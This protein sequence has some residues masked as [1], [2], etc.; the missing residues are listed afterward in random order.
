VNVRARTAAFFSRSAI[1]A[2]AAPALTPCAASNA[3]GSGASTSRQVASV[4][5]RVLVL[6][7]LALFTS[8][9]LASPASALQTHNQGPQVS[10]AATPNQAANGGGFGELGGLA[11]GGG[12]DLYVIDTT[13]S[14]SAGIENS[15]AVH[16]F[17]N[18]GAYQST[19]D[20]T[21]VV[22]GPG[23]LA[24]NGDSHLTVEPSGTLYLTDTGN[25]RVL[26]F[27]SAGEALKSFGTEGQL[28]GA[29]TPSGSFSYACGVAVDPI[30]GDV[31]LAD[32]FNHR[33]WIFDSSGTYQ[34]RIA[35][36][37]IS[38]PCGL[39]FDSTG[40]LYVR[41]WFAGNVV[42]FHRAGARD[43]GFER[44]A[45]QENNFTPADPTDDLPGPSDI[46]VDLVNNDLYVDAGSQVSHFDQ[47]GTLLS[48]FAKDTFQSGFSR[49]IAVDGMAGKVYA[50]DGN[51][52]LSFGPLVTL[53]EASTGGVT[54]ISGSEATVHG[55]V[56]PA[57]LDAECEFEYGTDTTYGSTAPC[58]PAGPYTSPTNVSAE[59]T[60]LLEGTV[61]HYRLRA[62]NVN[63][64][65]R[66]Q[67]AKFATDGAPIVSFGAAGVETTSA[68]LRASI[69]P[70]GSPA[71]YRFEYVEESQFQATGFG[72]AIK[73]PT[74]DVALGS[75]SSAK[76]VSRFVS[77]LSP[78]TK[79][80]FRVIAANAVGITET[81]PKSFKTYPVPAPAEA[82][83]F[84]GE[85]FLP[86]DRAWELVTPQ[87]KLGQQIGT[88]FSRVAVSSDGDKLTFVT[89]S[90]FADTMFMGATTEYM[91]KRQGPTA[92]TPSGWATHGI[93]PLQ[94]P[95]NG[96]AVGLG[97]EPL[98][99]SAFSD[100]LSTAVFRAM[101][102]LTEAPNVASTVA[103][104]YTR[105]DVDKPG[106]GT[107]ELVTSCPDSAC[108]S[109]LPFS[110]LSRPRFASASDD[111]DKILFEY[112]YRL[113]VGAPSNNNPKLY[114]TIAGGDPVYQG[115]VPTAPARDCGGAGPACDPTPAVRSVAGSGASGTSKSMQRAMT[116]DGSRVF[117]TV[118]PEN[119]AKSGSL[120]MRDDHNTADPSD[121]TTAAIAG[122]AGAS[123]RTPADA[124]GPASFWS[125][126]TGVD[127]Q[128]NRVP[129]RVFLTTKEK[130]TDD[131]DN[132]ANDLYM[133][134]EQA[135]GDG[136]HLQRLSIDEQPA[137]DVF[138]TGVEGLVG[139]NGVSED[140]E[141]VYFSNRGQL[142]AGQPPLEG[143][144]GIYLWH[145]GELTY[146]G[147]RSNDSFA[148]Q[149]VAQDT[150]GS[151][152]MT[153]NGRYLLFPMEN[154][155]SLLSAHGGE[156]VD[157]SQCPSAASADCWQYYLYSAETNS[158][159]CASCPASGAAPTGRISFGTSVGLGF[160]SPGN[161]INRRLSEDGRFAF[162]TTDSPLVPEDT[163]G[164]YDAYQYDAQSEEPKL[165]SNGENKQPSYFLTASPDGSD[166]F[167]LTAEPLSRHDI[168]DY[169][170]IYD[171]RAGGG[172]PEPPLPG[173]LCD[174]DA[175][176][177]PPVAL[178]D[179][180]PG[181]STLRGPGNSRARERKARCAKGARKVRRNGKT[182]CVKQR[183]S[184]R[185]AKHNGRASR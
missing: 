154:G 91:A 134:S 100:D 178:N 15:G 157:Q 160:H 50:S 32:A 72:N 47:F 96:S 3:K 16:R 149:L 99:I 62:T 24:L 76:A 105:R 13:G 139:P 103:N 153:P 31:L 166:A 92:E 53:P 136:H 86:S 82:G 56:E 20:G 142:A 66:G 78:A 174:G 135:D 183:K 127:E 14:A 29:E 173:G 43:F 109:P 55:S 4:S 19:I 112:P 116:A 28:T 27:D 60:G 93:V 179:P 48:T 18:T 97:I 87:N 185:T 2:D 169:Y 6:S 148:V 10:G 9:L 168:D 150:Q 25:A 182:R 132:T 90:A 11:V 68:T 175:C 122:I 8:L 58:L 140:G 49:S 152:R 144:Y 42:K 84:P 147:G 67:D 117:F 41:N 118:G 177:P 106:H 119:A 80:R 1:G 94:E 59:L 181:T 110:P 115:V 162:F 71:S 98:Y 21:D 145:E 102:P 69:N 38:G 83:Q 108:P 124:V 107:Y 5:P 40:E 95:Q 137:D 133:W 39:A 146:I 131:D 158:L 74:A 52:L 34:G 45:Y 167:V 164:T 114:K 141:Y 75:G 37:A 170:D 7:A 172:I 101:S 123:E 130:L 113:A 180:T 85:G 120:Y 138:A 156:D 12:G 121:D 35:D 184:K 17:D 63:G 36:S 161:S 151:A 61:Y 70:A 128:G 155:S 88:D 51:L 64:E 54:D 57:G 77:G 22:E 165:L 125:A 23:S 89:R 159:V 46:A 143:K 129:A 126:S 104:F 111:F 30:N 176:Q 81:A 163:N 26:A 44:V 79:Y 171:A 65:G 33:V 73:V